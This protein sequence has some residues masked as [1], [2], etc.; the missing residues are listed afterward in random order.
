MRQ[1]WLYLFQA[2]LFAALFS[3]SVSPTFSADWY[4][5]QGWAPIING[6][7]EGARAKAIENALRQSLDLAGGQIESVEEVV[8]GVITG[9][10]IQ[11]RS[12]G[13]IEQVELL[14][15][16]TN[17]QRHEVTIRTLV[18]PQQASC[19][20]AQFQQAVVITPFEAMNP[21]HLRHGAIDDISVAAAFRFSRLMGR[22]SQKF[23]IEHLLE[24]FQGVASR[25]RSNDSTDFSTWARRIGFEHN[26]QYVITGVFHDLN[27][28]PVS[29][30]NLAFWRHPNYERNYELS[31]YLV[32]ASSGAVITTASVSGSAAWGFDYNEAV[33]V[34]SESFWQSTFGEQLESKMR[35]VVY[36]FDQKLQCEPLRGRV[37]R[38]QGDEVMINLGSE[39][40]LAEGLK[41]RVLHRGGFFDSQGHYRE[42]WVVNPNEFE[43]SKIHSTSSTLR[44]EDSSHVL[45]VQV[46]D[47]VIFE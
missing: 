7:I 12:R 30:T 13:S 23:N 24:S 34:Q 41:A 45:G 20:G 26:S 18:Q 25:L 36:G 28:E 31:I 39:H 6:D 44:A 5:T 15:E 37:V 8:D 1:K 11:W 27:A 40:A 14:R 47:L 2:C 3:L 35:D 22:H 16:R 43:V 19:A 33:N 46:R 29:G 21:E 42:Q 38:A 32:E 10:S 17:G 9:Q 4:E